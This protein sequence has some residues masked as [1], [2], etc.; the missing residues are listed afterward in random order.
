MPKVLDLFCG[1]GGLAT[2][3]SQRGFDVTGV[4]SS[5]LAGETYEKNN[6][7][8]FVPLDLSR[9]SA[10]GDYDLVM[11]GPPCKPWS[12]VNTVARGSAHR[13][14]HLLGTFFRHVESI[15]PSRGPRTSFTSR[16]TSISLMRL[17]GSCRIHNMLGGGTDDTRDVMA[18][19]TA[20]R[21]PALP[22]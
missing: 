21:G 11:G 4:D 7:G 12:N 14:Y 10:T 9:E 8:K 1:A 3:F 22:D 19:T 6:R 20:Q 13:D 16:V 2:G 5:G 18:C 15:R 17:H